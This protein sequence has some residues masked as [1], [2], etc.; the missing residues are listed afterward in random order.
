MVR[1]VRLLVALSTLFA[2]VP[3]LAI[4]A[5]AGPAR[6]AGRAARVLG[7]VLQQA[8]DR[9]IPKGLLSNAYA[10]AVIPDVIKVGLVLGGRHGEGLVA[11]KSPDGHWSDPAYVTL[12]GGSVG[13]QAGVS[14]TDVVL[15]FRTARGVDTLVNGKF[16]LGVD[17]HAAAGPVGRN[18]SASTDVALQSEI[19][20]YSR[21]RGLFAGVALDGSSLRIDDAADA[22]MYGGD[23]TARQIFDGKAGVPPAAL[24]DFRA[25]L[26]H[27]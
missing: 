18:A 16:T 7:E 27:Y 9:A 2:M 5:A 6:I 3:S 25:R 26:E 4:G 15:V 17:A 19:Y 13:F 22:A 21:S 14:S 12:T 10:V 8:P 23:Y 11:V 20:S 1:R 24:S